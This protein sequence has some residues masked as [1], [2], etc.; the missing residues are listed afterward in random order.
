MTDPV[1]DPPAEP[2]QPPV[3]PT[4]ETFPPGYPDRRTDVGKGITRPA[5]H[6]GLKRSYSFS[7]I[8]HEYDMFDW[9]WRIA[10]CIVGVLIGLAIGHWLWPI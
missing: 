6:T 10:F 7:P 5:M 4:E 1:V 3:E 2:A 8:A 9:S